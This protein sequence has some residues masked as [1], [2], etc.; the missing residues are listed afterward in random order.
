MLL[1]ISSS[2]KGLKGINQMSKK[3]NYSI[4]DVETMS[5]EEMLADLPISQS[6]L[7]SE[8]RKKMLLWSFLGIFLAVMFFVV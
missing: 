8:Q 4:S 6:E 3:S 7:D 2:L 5:R 1:N